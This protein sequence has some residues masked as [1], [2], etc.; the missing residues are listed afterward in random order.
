MLHL[1]YLKNHGAVQFSNLAAENKLLGI[2]F[3]LLSLSK[4]SKDEP[5]EDRTASKATGAFDPV[6]LLFSL[7]V[8]LKKC[9]PNCTAASQGGQMLELQLWLCTRHPKADWF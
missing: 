2:T 8:R 9:F 7:L 4:G 5:A 1:V 6:K 3:Y